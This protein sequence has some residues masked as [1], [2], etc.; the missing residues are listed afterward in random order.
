MFADA[1]RAGK[2]LNELKQLSD[3]VGRA[4]RNKTAELLRLK[5]QKI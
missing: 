5:K 3:I 1:S 2:T 4:T